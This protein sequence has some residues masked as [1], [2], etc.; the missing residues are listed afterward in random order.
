M[1][2]GSTISELATTMKRK[3]LSQR[4]VADE[5]DVSRQLIYNYIYNR[6][7]PKEVYDKAAKFVNNFTV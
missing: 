1:I 5:I 7:M 2:T 6:R 4:E 3:H